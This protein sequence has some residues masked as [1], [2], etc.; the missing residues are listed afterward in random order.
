M[1]TL[2]LLFLFP[3]SAWATYD[4]KCNLFCYNGGQCLHGKGKFGQYTDT[5]ST[6]APLPWDRTVQPGLG[7]YCACPSGFSGMQCELAMEVCTANS[8]ICFN[9]Q[10]CTHATDMNGKSW[11]YCGCDVQHSDMKAPY[12]EKYCE[13]ISTVFCNKG[14]GDIGSGS[15]SYCTNGGKCKKKT[16]PGQ[17]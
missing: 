5:S 7:M 15:K 11:F 4:W 12:A 8:M 2:Q 1:R 13:K 17:K 3:L 10:A 9:G 6:P 16:Q 14:S